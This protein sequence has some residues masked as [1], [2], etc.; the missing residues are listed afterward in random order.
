MIKGTEFATWEREELLM[1]KITIEMP[2]V[3][4]CE[5]SGCG[6]NVEKKCHAKA[7]T[8]GDSSEPECDTFLSSPL[9]KRN[10][11]LIAGV[12]A[13]KVGGCRF[14]RDFECTAE[15]INVGMNHSKV[16]CLTYS[17]KAE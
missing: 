3:S 15:T 1:K 7:I 8:I 13:C 9:H 5:I 10:T 16:N 11:K 6:Y 12:G 17:P 14:N 2:M 4:S